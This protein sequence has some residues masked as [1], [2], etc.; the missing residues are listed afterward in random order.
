MKIFVASENP[1]KIKAVKMAFTKYYIFTKNYIESKIEVIPFKTE[2]G[3]GHTPSDGTILTGAMNRVHKLK[4]KGEAD[5]YVGIESGIF[6]TPNHGANISELGTR[7]YIESQSGQHGTGTSSMYEL[8]DFVIKQ[9]REGRELGDII[10]KISLEDNTKQNGGAIDLFS[11][12][13]FNRLDV[14]YSS[15]ISALIPFMNPELYF[16]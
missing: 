12:H 5:Y 2:S 4:Q 6:F 3:V 1:V 15:V 14:T 10:D 8:P 9:I 16:K 11:H 7:T 13:I